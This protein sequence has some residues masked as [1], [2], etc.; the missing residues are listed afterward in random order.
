MMN[1]LTDCC[2]A[3]LSPNQPTASEHWTE[4]EPLT[5]TIQ[6]GKTNNWPHLV[7]WSTNWL[8]KDEIVQLTLYQLS[9]ASTYLYQ[10]CWKLLW[11]TGAHQVQ[12]SEML[13]PWDHTGLEDKNNLA[14]APQHWPQL[15]IWGENYGRSLKHLASFGKDRPTRVYNSVYS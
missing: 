11:W 9:N 12:R 2:L 10:A 3:L 14:S 5:P 7:S 15:K 4:L 6:R 1:G 8:L 13:R